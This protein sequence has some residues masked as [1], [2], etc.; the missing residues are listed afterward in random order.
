MPWGASDDALEC[1]IASLSPAASPSTP[2]SKPSVAFARMALAGIGATVHCHNSLAVADHLEAEAAG[3]R[4]GR[5]RGGDSGRVLVPGAG[6]QSPGSTASQ[7]ALLP[8]LSEADRAAIDGATRWPDASARAFHQIEQV[9]AVAAAHENERFQ[10]QYGP[11]G[12]QWC[13]DAT[14]ERIAAASAENDRRVHMHLLES[15]RQREWLDATYRQGIVR[16]LDDIGL[17]SPRLT[18]AHGV[19]LTDEECALMAERSVTVAVNTS[20]NLRL[21]S[22]VAPVARFMHHGLAFGF[23]LDG[24]AHDD[25]QDYFRDLRLAWRLHN[26]T[27]LEPALPPARLFD[28]ACRHGFRCIDGSDDYGEIAPRR[29]GRPGDA[30]LRRRWCEDFLTPERGRGRHRARP[31]RPP[32]TCATS[33]SRGAGWSAT[34]SSSGWTCR[35]SE[36]EFMDRAR[37]AAALDAEPGRPPPAA[38]RRRTRLLCGRRPPA[39]AL[40]G[41]SRRPVKLLQRPDARRET[42]CPHPTR[43]GLGI[44]P[45]QFPRSLEARGA[46]I[47]DALAQANASQSSQGEPATDEGAAGGR[48]ET[49][50]ACRW[51]G[52]PG[53]QAIAGTAYRGRNSTVRPSTLAAFNAANADRSTSCSRES[54]KFPG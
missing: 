32:A 47:A 3:R 1:W 12:P 10:V 44:S 39:L 6:P 31:V 49:M 40:R 48:P 51:I 19:H 28:A 30:R 50:R 37:R 38:P 21:R 8:Y 22:G 16:F 53:L 41:D 17:L 33:S 26:G 54:G 11:I 34:V 5:G 29:P 13:E 18:V 43:D 9:E 45:D 36:R 14:L 20:C 2:G 25:D 27:G 52:L 35:T 15:R 7:R 4:E 46:L 23:G 24:C 42:G